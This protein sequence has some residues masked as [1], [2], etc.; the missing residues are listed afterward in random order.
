M[1]AL[2][3]IGCIPYT[4]CNGGV[5]GGEHTADLLIVGSYLRPPHVETV[6]EAA[7]R[8]GVGLTNDRNG[9]IYAVTDDPRAMIGFAT[10]LGGLDS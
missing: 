6:R 4:S 8:A 10:T 3:A 9:G 1:V 7:R 2:S 5:F